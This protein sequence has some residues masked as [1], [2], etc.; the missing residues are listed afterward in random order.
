LKQKKEYNHEILT[1]ERALFQSENV[2]I[3]NTIFADGE[4]PLKESRNIEI[5]D[6]IFKWKY[7]VWY[8]RNI[9]VKNSTWLETARAGVW[10]TDTIS[11]E[12]SIIQAPKSFRRCN[13]ILLKNVS[14]PNAAE[15]LWNCST[16]RLEH[17]TAQGDYF[18]MNSEDMTITD[19]SLT[20]GYAFDGVRNV[21]IHNA[22]ILTKDA[23][24][25]SRDVTVY[26]SF[27]SSEYLGWNSKNLTLVNCTIESLQGMCYCD[28]LVLKDC[29][30]L[31]TS[32]AFE[33][34]TVDAEIKGAID[35]VKNPSGGCIRA[36]R[37]D[38]LIMEADK[39]DVSKTKI[40]CAGKPVDVQRG[41]LKAV[42]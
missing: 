40:Y 19:F 2:H 26:D 4:S 11:V 38:T 16:A 21:E 14:L 1:G 30:L 28:S 17:V 35:S 9:S 25:N 15:T 22:K 23:F 3:V 13:G 24:W 37:I 6:S 34:S 20:G 33:Y 12:D 10:Y 18:A 5:E 36:D 8:S 32:L 31:N 27:I 42:V 7:P 39:V 41:N 29:T